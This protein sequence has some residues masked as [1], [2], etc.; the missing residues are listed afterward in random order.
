MSEEF[1]LL[2]KKQIGILSDKFIK[3]LN[4]IPLYDTDAKKKLFSEY[5]KQ[6]EIMI[7]SNMK[8]Y[9]HNNSDCDVNTLLRMMLTDRM[10]LSDK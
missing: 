7:T 10:F 3:E 8:N 4:R 9:V 2:S 5:I 6:F 1:I